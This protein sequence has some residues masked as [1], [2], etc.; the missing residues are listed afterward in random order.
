[1]VILRA[2]LDEYSS[3]V[4]PAGRSGIPA[5]TIDKL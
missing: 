3:S 4:Y 2:I 5:V 1:V